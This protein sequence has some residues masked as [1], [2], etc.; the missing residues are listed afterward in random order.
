MLLYIQIYNRIFEFH[1]NFNCLINSKLDSNRVFFQFDKTDV[2][3]LIFIL[4]EMIYNDCYY[5]LDN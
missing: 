2:C 1:K 5:Y 3:R 4:T